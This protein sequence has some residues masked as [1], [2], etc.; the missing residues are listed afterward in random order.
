M[1]TIKKEQVDNDIQTITDI[2]RDKYEGVKL[3][4]VG[5]KPGEIIIDNPNDFAVT[6]TIS[7]TKKYLLKVYIQ[8]EGEFRVETDAGTKPFNSI[9]K[10]IEYV[11][12]FISKYFHIAK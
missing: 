3:T 12:K 6:L 9:D 10:A 5:I 8:Y 2:L 4:T 7:G 1:I 11:D